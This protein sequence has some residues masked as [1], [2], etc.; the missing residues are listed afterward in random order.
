MKSPFQRQ[1]FLSGVVV[2]LP[3]SRLKGTDDGIFSFILK[4]VGLYVKD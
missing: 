3:F 2:V 1:V 4:W